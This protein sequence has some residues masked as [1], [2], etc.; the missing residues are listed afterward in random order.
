MKGSLDSHSVCVCVCVPRCQQEVEEGE[1]G[2][3]ENEE[4]T[5]C[6]SRCNW[7]RSGR[8]DIPCKGSRPAS[9]D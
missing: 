1:G 7:L 3:G 2:G 8:S 4:G 6:Q 9:L 5:V